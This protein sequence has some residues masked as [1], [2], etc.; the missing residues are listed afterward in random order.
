[1]IYSSPME[2]KIKEVVSSDKRLQHMYMI[3]VEKTTLETFERIGYTPSSDIKKNMDKVWVNSSRTDFLWQFIY[4][5]WG[6]D[7]ESK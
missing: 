1:M 7:N 3:D 5:V 2:K 6:M 4:N